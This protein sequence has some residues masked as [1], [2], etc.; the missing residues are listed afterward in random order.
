MLWPTLRKT[1]GGR[2]NGL[3]YWG[4]DEVLLSTQITV[5]SFP[6][7]CQLGV[8]P[9]VPL[10]STSLSSSLSTQHACFWCTPDHPSLSIFMQQSPK[11]SKMS[12]TI[13]DI[14]SPL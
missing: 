3:W 7:L 9:L 4:K 13:S 6:R 12:P 1:S 10:C 5:C 14:F 8:S 11:L 2:G